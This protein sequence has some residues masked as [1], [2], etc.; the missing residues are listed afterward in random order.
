[1]DECKSRIFLNLKSWV[2]KDSAFESRN[3]RCLLAFLF[4]SF[5]VQT[6]VH[7]DGIISIHSFQN[8][9]FKIYEGM[10]VQKEKCLY[11]VFH[12]KFSLEKKLGFVTFRFA[13]GRCG[14]EK[15]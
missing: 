4:T 9:T 7:D 12:L 11:Y 15:K 1:M 8:Y 2:F 14:M 5:H 10:R 3:L 13:D 6:S